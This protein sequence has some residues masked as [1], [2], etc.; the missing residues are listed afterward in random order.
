MLAK[1]QESSLLQPIEKFM[2]FRYPG[3][4]LFPVR[5]SPWFLFLI[6][7]SLRDLRQAFVVCQLLFCSHQLFV[8]RGRQKHSTS[9]HPSVPAGTRR[10]RSHRAR[11]LTRTGP[12]R[13]MRESP[14]DCAF[15][16]RLL[17]AVARA[18]PS[19][20]KFAPVLQSSFLL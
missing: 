6:C 10:Y 12:L 3:P 1:I 8:S 5:I 9:L 17:C 13:T 2:A 20:C 7:A 4:D 18:K 11:K 16:F 15:E 14:A 19:T